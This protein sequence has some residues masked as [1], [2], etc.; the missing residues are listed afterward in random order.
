MER[1]LP[2]IFGALVLFVAGVPLHAEVLYPEVAFDAK[3]AAARLAP[4]TAS[5]EGVAY[6]F[7]D[8]MPA[9]PIIPI[10][11]RMKSPLPWNRVYAEG[12]QVNLLP[13]TEYVT[14]WLK[15]R[16][17]REGGFTR[18][19]RQRHSR[20][21]AV[22]M[23]SDEALSHRRSVTAGRKGRFRFDQLKPGRYL[24]LAFM[25]FTVRRNRLNAWNEQ[26]MTTAGPGIAMHQQ[27]ETYYT[28]QT[29]ELMAIV[30]VR[31]EGEVR[32]VKLR[33][34]IFSLSL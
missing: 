4:G 13:M 14:A 27:W 17:R 7:R 8:S 30:E 20:D 31:R 5:I 25:D 34:R 10:P 28:Q 22:V 32:K 6:G 23:L 21:P 18:E 29:P 19:A 15:L 26:V 2:R 16:K 11:V 1:R 9:L 12:V 3:D 24:L 33:E